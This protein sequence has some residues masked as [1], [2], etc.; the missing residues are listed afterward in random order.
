MTPPQPN[1][2]YQRIV[3]SISTTM[4]MPA[5]IW[6]PDVGQKNLKIAAAVGLPARYIAEAALPL[7]GISPTVEAFRSGKVTSTRDILHDERWH[8]KVVAREMGWKSALCVPVKTQGQSVAAISI[9]AFVNRDFSDLEKRLLSDYAAQIELRLESEQRHNALTRL[10]EISDHIQQSI[11]LQPKQVLQAIVNGACEVVGADCAV[12]YPYDAHREDFYDIDRVAHSGLRWPLELTEKP[13][14]WGMASLV[15]Q[16]EEKIVTDIEQEDPD[17][18][19]YKFIQREGIKAFVGIALQA[20]GET[21]GILY[22]NFRT[23]RQIP[24]GDLQTI[25]LFARQASAALQNVHFFEHEQ[26]LQ[27]IACELSSELDVDQLLNNILTQALTLLSC[28][29]GS[30]AIWEAES[31]QLVYQYA[32]GKEVGARVEAG[33]GLMNTAATSRQIVNVGDVKHDPRYFELVAETQSELD[34]PLIA[35]NELLGVL[36]LESTRLNAFG[37]DDEQLARAFASQA[38]VALYNAQLF[39][40]TQQQLEQRVKDLQA[41][42]E[43]Y[44]AVGQE[45]VGTVFRLVLERAVNLT[46]ASYGNLWLVDQKR[47]DLVFGN[48]INRLPSPSR[49][50][51]RIP[52]DATSINGCVALTGKPYLSADVT[53]D[54]HYQQI[55]KDIRSELAVPLRRDSRVIGTLNVESVQQAAFTDSHRR[56]LEALA[57]QA[58]I[59]IEDAH[60][61]ERLETLIEVGQTLTRGSRLTEIEVLDLIRTQADKLMDAGNMYIALYDG[62]SDIVRFGLAYVDGERIDVENHPLWQPRKA[63]K[64]RTEEIIRSK[65]SIFIATQAESEEWYKQPGREEYVGV[66]FASWMGVPMIVGDKTVGVIAIY[67][68]LIDNVYTTEDLR[69][70]KALGDEAAIALDNARLLAETQRLSSEKIANQELVAL[71]AAMAAIQHR[72]NNSFNVIVPNVS[73]LRKRVDLTDPA[74][75]E[76][77]DIIDRNARST[78]VMINRLQEPLQSIDEQTV[79]LN[80]LIND[81]V[82]MA[83]EAWQG[84]PGVE[85]NMQ[86]SLGG[87]IP[88]FSAPIGQLTE[89]FRNLL[90]NAR[91]VLA[92]CESNRQILVTTRYVNGIIETR[93]EDD[94]P[95]IPVAIEERLFKKPVPS[96]DQNSG[97]GLGL[98]LTRIILQRISGGIRVERTGVSG[99]VMLVSIPVSQPQQGGKNDSAN[100]NH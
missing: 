67:H 98:W 96:K 32:T 35:R 34:V 63:G 36:N 78:S 37:E 22:V 77:L 1:D 6:A 47:H 13:R 51:E 33:K 4:N 59:A 55:L 50:G 84:T 19:N 89:V 46:D 91:A 70:L 76:I 43:V 66:A 58:A 20:R 86:L 38:A 41:L 30:I 61:Y 62:A 2:L 3:D 11:A 80:A 14:K 94:G 71:G 90:D 7:D 57:G 45:P 17:L 85:V 75:V 42:Q 52:I 16:Q 99:T 12:L 10:L 97:A 72:I 73:R 54:E 5:S 23:P 82:G 48:E 87:G 93:V 15:R 24:P 53:Q 83:K 95:G 64:G 60:L 27:G 44:G 65:Q 39:A 81:V 49:K 79:D 29:V 26:A 8:Y 88:T 69:I 68:P 21:Q 18:L 31:S 25:R 40:R 74:I 9:Y 56:L 92:K 28:P 100:L